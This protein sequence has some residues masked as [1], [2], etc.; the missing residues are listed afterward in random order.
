MR[1]AVTWILLLA[2]AS[3]NGAAQT[4]ATVERYVAE[5]QQEIFAEFVS[6]LSI[7]NVASDK[8]NIR[9]NAEQLRQML[10]RRGFAAE[11]L[12]TDVNPL[13]YGDLQIP[14]ASRTILWY[15]HYDGQP[16]DPKL[17]KQRALFTPSCAMAAWKTA[18]RK[19]RTLRLQRHTLR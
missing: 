10:S 9:K 15:A 7:P 19:F 11:I 1:K 17:W 8:P 2:L 13:V 18:R 4:R 12:E 14:G 5:H 16:V 6:L 3:L